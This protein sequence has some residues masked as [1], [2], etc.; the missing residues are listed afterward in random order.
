MSEV[1]AAPVEMTTDGDIAQQQ[2][3]QYGENEPNGFY[4]EKVKIKNY[5]LSLLNI[6]LAEISPWIHGLDGV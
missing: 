4:I 6:H 3:N 5:R 2:Q 1:E